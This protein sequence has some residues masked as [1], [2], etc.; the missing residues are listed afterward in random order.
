VR[1]IEP[2]FGFGRGSSSQTGASN[3]AWPAYR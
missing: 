2:G 3:N 1:E